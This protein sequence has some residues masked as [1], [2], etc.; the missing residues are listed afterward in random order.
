MEQEL[1]NTWS[2]QQYTRIISSQYQH[3]SGMKQWFINYWQCS[4]LSYNTQSS[5]PARMFPSHGKDWDWR[6]CTTSHYSNKKNS[7]GTKREVQER[8]RQTS[9]P[10]G[11]RPSRQTHSMGQRCGGGDKEFWNAQNLHGSKTTECSSEAQALSAS[12]PWRH[13]AWAG[14]SQG[15]LNRWLMFRL[16]A[17]R[18]GWRVQSNHHVHNTFWKVPVVQAPIWIICVLWNVP[19]KSESGSDRL[20]RHVRHSRWRL[21]ILSWRLRRAGQCRPWPEV[22]QTAREMSVTR[23]S[24]NPDKLKL[25]T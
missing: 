6:K 1:H 19:E 11:N 15:I 20:R 7:Q 18:P 24:L 21:N 12:Y 25:C 22:D 5:S 10:R 14:T 13:L 17:L 8:S 16:L 3:P 2:F 9:E 4:K 23:H